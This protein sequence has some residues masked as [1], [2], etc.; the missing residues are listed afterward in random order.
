MLAASVMAP[1]LGAQLPTAAVTIEE[2][3]PPFGPAA[4]L[5]PRYLY[6]SVQ[7]S[8]QHSGYIER[9]KFH[10]WSLPLLSI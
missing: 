2:A 3:T 7:C 9:C 6:R 8:L 4:P 1:I 10:L 5:S